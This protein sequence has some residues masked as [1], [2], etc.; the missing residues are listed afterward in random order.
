MRVGK[1]VGRPWVCAALAIVLVIAGAGQS[2]ALDKIVFGNPNPAGLNIG[3]APFYYAKEMGFF[4]QEGIEVE[5]VNF[6]GGGVLDPQLVNKS[7]DIGWQGPD[8]IVIS[9]DV[10]K[11]PLPLRYFY[12]HL[13]RYVWEITVPA[14][15]KIMEL[16][17]LKGAKIGVNSL[18]TTSVTTTKSMLTAAGLDPDKDVSFLAVG[19]GGPAFQALKTHQ[20]DAMNL[21]DTMDVALENTGYKLRRLELPPRYT[22]L[23]ENSFATH[24]DNLKDK[25]KQLV[26]FA[27]AIAKATVGCYAN[28][29]ACVKI[30]WKQDPK[31]KSANLSEELALKNALAVLEIRGKSYWSF[32]NGATGHWGEFSDAMWNNRVEL[33]HENKIIKVEKIDAKNFYS[34]ELIADINRFDTAAVKKQAEALK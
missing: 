3:M 1:S 20:I 10:G 9:N 8:S 13:R 6:N 33:L 16:K 29:P 7:V 4:E 2:K 26:G 11:T 32:P 24:V 18:A 31:T 30:A 17:D 14:D 25:K 23:F 12:N 28:L 15:S 22:M 34:N 5:Y 19:M 27:R 21:F